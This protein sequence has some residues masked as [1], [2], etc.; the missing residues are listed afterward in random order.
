M[1]GI[2]IFPPGSAIPLHKHNCDEAVLVLEG[3][4]VAEIAGTERDVFSG[5]VS[6][7]P[8]GVHHRFR[9]ASEDTLRIFWTYASVDADRT[10]IATGI[11][12]RIEDELG[13]SGAGATAPEVP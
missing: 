13:L 10:I 5:D 1:N 8:Q 9:N 11:T 4:A 3:R 6:F 2:T 7:I 12:R